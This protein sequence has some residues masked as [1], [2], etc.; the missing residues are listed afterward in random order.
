MNSQDLFGIVAMFVAVMAFPV[1]DP[2]LLVMVLLSVPVP[3]IVWYF[4]ARF[5]A[6]RADKP[7]EGSAA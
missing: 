1:L 7:T 5:Y 3:I 2:Q 6:S 4:L